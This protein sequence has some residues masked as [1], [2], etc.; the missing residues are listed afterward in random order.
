M[1]KFSHS[2][3]DIW[4][5]ITNEYGDDLGLSDEEK[6]EIGKKYSLY[7]ESDDPMNDKDVLAR[8]DED[9]EY[10]ENMTIWL[11][12]DDGSQHEFEL[13]GRIDLE[14]RTYVLLHPMESEDDSELIAV[15][16][17]EAENGDAVF[18][19]IEDEAEM[20]EV[21]KA[22]DALLFDDPDAE[23]IEGGG[24]HD[25]GC[26]GEKTPVPAEAI[27]LCPVL[28]CL[29][30]QYD[31]HKYS[32]VKVAPALYEHRLHLCYHVLVI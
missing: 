30:Q 19:D 28:Q 27:P 2:D 21:Q 15:R 4:E 23:E 31:A 22:V 1:G 13:V 10:V 5:D 26:R 32:N 18:S 11:T 29:G 25:D 16:A 8:P 7:N 24:H 17:T 20:E 6:E 3:E 14:E 9:V 12:A